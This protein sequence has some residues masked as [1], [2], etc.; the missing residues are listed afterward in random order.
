M[1]WQEIPEDKQIEE[2]DVIKTHHCIQ[3]PEVPFNEVLASLGVEVGKFTGRINDELP[4]DCLEVRVVNR[5]LQRSEGL[6][7]DGDECEFVYTVTHEVTRAPE[8][9]E[10]EL[11]TASIVST[12]AT[13]A[14]SALVVGL[15]I[16]IVLHKTEQLF[17]GES[18]GTASVLVLAGLVAAVGYA[19]G[20]V[21]DALEEHEE[22]A[23]DAVQEV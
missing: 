16:T 14:L 5:D 13:V 15:A 19:S 7:V 18:G 6:V 2:G 17:T 12:A 8:E 22:T 9:C 21:D 4:G 23:H 20:Q 11:Q 3:A 10:P 1:P